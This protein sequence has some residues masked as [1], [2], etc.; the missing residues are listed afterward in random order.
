MPPA[1]AV[2]TGIPDAAAPGIELRS[3]RKHYGEVVAVADLSLSVARGEFLVLLGPSGCGKTTTLRLIG[4][5]EL[6]S[7][8]EVLIDGE[9]MGNRPPYRR[10]VNTVFQ[11]YAL[12]PHMTVGRN[13]AYGMEM[14]GVPKPERARRVGEALELVRL[15]HVER[16]KP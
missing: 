11:D 14:A 16:R 6:P 9:A 15:P 8:G 7:A 2:R 12:F 1:T 4:G 13:V 5:F 3:V 10:P